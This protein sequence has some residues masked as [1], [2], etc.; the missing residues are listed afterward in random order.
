MNFI[1]FESDRNSSKWSECV[2]IVKFQYQKVYGAEIEVNP[3][4][5]A[6]LVRR[7]G[8][9]EQVLAC[10]GYKLHNGCTPLFSERYL[11]RP[12]EEEAF[13]LTGMKFKKTDFCEVGNMASIGT[14]EGIELIRQLPILTISLNKKIALVTMTKQ[15]QFLLKRIRLPFYEISNARKDRVENSEMWGSY[16]DNQPICS[17]IVT[18]E[19]F[20]SCNIKET[21]I[22]HLEL[23]L[24]V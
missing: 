20:I 14:Q 12:I 17:L 8:A 21:K 1:A 19:A 15:I 18:S 6:I 13:E 16:Y 5:F 4:I 11:D 10:I 24:L 3:D 2:H 23:E 7:D 22:N 9:R